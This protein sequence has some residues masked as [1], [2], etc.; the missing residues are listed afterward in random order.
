MGEK[1]SGRGPHIS[2][3][4]ARAGFTEQELLKLGPGG[5]KPAKQTPGGML[6]AEETAGTKALRRGIGIARMPE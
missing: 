1:G 6:Q 3:R 4:E 2:G 5:R